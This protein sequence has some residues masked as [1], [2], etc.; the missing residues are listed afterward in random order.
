MKGRAM[1][2]LGLCIGSQPLGLLEMGAI[3]TIFNTNAAIGIN[4]IAASL[5]LI[6]IV[7]LTRLASGD[8]APALHEKDSHKY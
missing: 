2:V 5:L 8:M 7:V 6:P 4:A 1:G 3:A